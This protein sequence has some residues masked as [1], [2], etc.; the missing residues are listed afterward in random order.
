MRTDVVDWILFSLDDLVTVLQAEGSHLTGG[1]DTLTEGGKLN[2]DGQ[3]VIFLRV[4]PHCSFTDIPHHCWQTRCW[5]R[6]ADRANQPENDTEKLSQKA[7]Q[8]II[9]Y[10]RWTA[11]S[12]EAVVGSIQPEWPVYTLRRIVTVPLYKHV[13][14]CRPS[15]LILLHPFQFC[16]FFSPSLKL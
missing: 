14:Y 11:A 7:T 1:S 4:H 2:F 13:L 12:A 8:P 3:R 15:S 5:H 16:F 9:W 10:F 6:G